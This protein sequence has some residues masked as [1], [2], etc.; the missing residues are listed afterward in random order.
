MQCRVLLAALLVHWLTRLWLLRSLWIQHSCSRVEQAAD[1]VG[2]RQPWWDHPAQT[3]ATQDSLPGIGS[4]LTAPSI[5]G[6]HFSQAAELIGILV[7]PG[8]LIPR[9]VSVCWHPPR[10]E[11]RPTGVYVQVLII[12]RAAEQNP[13]PTSWLPNPKIRD[14]EA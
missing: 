8:R 2:D 11:H 4:R 5:A 1:A 10:S 13:Y 7:R 9:R 6:R 14:Q 3:E 12:A